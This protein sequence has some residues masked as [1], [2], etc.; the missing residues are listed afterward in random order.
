[1][2]QG[3]D[4]FRRGGLEAAIV[5]FTRAIQLDPTNEQALDARSI[6][7]DALGDSRRAIADRTEIIRFNP[8]PLN[9][10]MRGVFAMDH[11][12]AL[13]IADFT[14]ATRQQPNHADAYGLRA[15]VYEQRG[16]YDLA[17]TDYTAAQVDVEDPEGWTEDVARVRRLL[18]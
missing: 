17:L 3:L 5:S 1:M 13:A 4:Q 2:R 10:H 8:S 7:Y 18:R 6:A 14:K 15:M 9:F 16:R 12:P 11:D